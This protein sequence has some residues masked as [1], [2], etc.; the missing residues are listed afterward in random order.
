MNK[1]KPFR[2]LKVKYILAD[3]RKDAQYICQIIQ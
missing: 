1:V 2:I 3:K